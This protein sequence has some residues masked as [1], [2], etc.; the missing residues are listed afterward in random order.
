MIADMVT[1]TMLV[2]AVVT[3][4]FSWFFTL[5][6]FGRVLIEYYRGDGL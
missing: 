1:H 5:W 2:I 6:L 4:A 3:V